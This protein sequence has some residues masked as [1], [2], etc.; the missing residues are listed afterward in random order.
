MQE[1]KL[2]IQSNL[3]NNIYDF[4]ITIA[5]SSGSET[6]TGKSIKWVKTYP[7]CWP[8]YIFYTNF[9]K[10][11]IG[12]EIELLK[13]EIR[14]GTAPGSWFLGPDSAAVFQPGGLEQYGF[15][16]AFS[17]PGMVLA[18][19]EMGSDFPVSGNFTIREVDNLNDLK[20]WSYVINAGMFGHGFEG[21]ALF[22]NLLD[23][24]DVKLFL[25]F[26]NGLPVSTSLLYMNSGIAGLFLIAT[27]PDFR[28]RGFG[29]RM[30]AAPVKEARKNGYDYT[31][32]F[33]TQ[34]GERIYKKI[35]F[36]RIC[37][38]DIYYL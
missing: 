33:A 35:G 11:R 22:R 12:D 19:G 3:E 16:K 14:S 7:S 6:G 30:T 9:A 17:W 10:K 37:D 31:G 23:K 21:V 15:K 32:L 18:I 34:T 4:Y 27:L 2:S 5:D 36:R 26:H 25:G 20:K 1:Q 8:N 24:K 38:F 28:H 29:T 13:E